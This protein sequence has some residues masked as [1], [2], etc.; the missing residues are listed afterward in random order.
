[1]ID[2]ALNACDRCGALRKKVES[3]PAGGLTAEAGGA[4]Q[5]AD[6]A[7][8]QAEAEFVPEIEPRVASALAVWVW[9]LAVFAFI[10]I[11]GLVPTLALAVF[12]TMVTLRRQR[13]AWDRR[14]GIAGMII[15]CASLGITGLWVLM[16]VLSGPFEVPEPGEFLVADHRSWA[17]AAMQLGVL[18]MSIVLHE[19]A[20]AVSAYWSGDGTAARLGRIRLNPLVHVDLFGSIILPGILLMT[21]GGVVFGWAKPVPIERRQF[22]N[23]RRGLLAVTLAG[24]S[25]NMML[26]LACAAG[27]LAVGSTLRIAYPDATSDGFMMPFAGVDLQG[28]ANDGAWEL[29]I[30]GLKQGLLVNLVLFTFNIL[31]IPPLDGY[32]VLESLAPE[33]LSPLVAGLRPLGF[34]LLIGF[35]VTGIIGYLLLPAIVIGL[36]LNLA[37]GAMTGWA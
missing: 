2:D 20:H 33:A 7:L 13:Y 21:P 30:T 25:V 11:L 27:L 4:E 1:M 19:C 26:A 37:V 29:T 24:V 23:P 17:V 3:D 16:L 32:G 34:F 8:A 6:S 14:I 28:V 35:I 18:V 22:R 10:P 36:I 31:P 12:S 9:I 15:A 5:V